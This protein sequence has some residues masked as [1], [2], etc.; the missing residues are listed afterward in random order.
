MGLCQ[1]IVVFELHSGVYF[2]FCQYVSL[3]CPLHT[4][5]LEDENVAKYVYYCMLQE[6]LIE[7]NTAHKNTL[8]FT[9]LRQ[10]D[11]KVGGSAHAT[12]IWPCDGYRIQ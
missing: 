12:L 9:L 7:T 1:V 6:Y 8:L 4:G 11:I 2:N 10:P 3:Q 5:Y